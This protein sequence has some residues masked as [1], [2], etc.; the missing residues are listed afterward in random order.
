MADQDVIERPVFFAGSAPAI[1]PMPTQPVPLPDWTGPEANYNHLFVVRILD[2]NPKSTRVEIW[3][4][5]VRA[6]QSDLDQSDLDLAANG[7]GTLV[8]GT[9]LDLVLGS[10]VGALVIFHLVDD[11]A[12]FWDAD[13]SGNPSSAVVKA[14]GADDLIYQARWVKGSEQNQKAVSVILETRASGV[15]RRQDYGL[16]VKMTDSISGKIRAIYIDPKVENDGNG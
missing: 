3:D 5:R 2:S 9:D 6:L 12:T 4:I 11:T 1:A 14:K 10:S 13:A 7:V 15:Y 8:S 16:G